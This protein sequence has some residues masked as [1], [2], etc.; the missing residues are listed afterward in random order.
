MV[1]RLISHK[2]TPTSEPFASLYREP[3]LSFTI[4]SFP[5]IFTEKE[6]S[7]STLDLLAPLSHLTTVE[8]IKILTWLSWL[9]TCPGPLPSRPD[10]RNELRGLIDMLTIRAKVLLGVSIPKQCIDKQYLL[11]DQSATFKTSETR[12]VSDDEEEPKAEKDEEEVE[13]GTTN[14]RF[15][16]EVRCSLSNIQ[17]G[18]RDVVR[19]E[20][21]SRSV[22]N[23][24]LTLVLSYRSKLMDMI[25]A[26][27]MS[28]L[29][30]AFG[31]FSMNR[32]ITPTDREMFILQFP[33]LQGHVSNAMTVMQTK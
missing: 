27:P 25:T 17:R 29:E 2:L 28:T 26:F 19:F 12:Y 20:T 13:L 15:L 30:E 21:W 23:E 18:V 1:L 33:M 32:R 11:M 7:R 16:L 6:L 3:K 9:Y 10:V 4:T 14:E 24:E 5:R 31:M 8:L 22:P